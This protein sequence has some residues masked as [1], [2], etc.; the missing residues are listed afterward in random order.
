MISATEAKTVDMNECIKLLRQ[1]QD[2]DIMKAYFEADI[3]VPDGE[4]FYD[5]IYEEVWG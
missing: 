2:F 3:E 1:Y 4:R 5:P